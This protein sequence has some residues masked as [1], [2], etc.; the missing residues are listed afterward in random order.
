MRRNG[1]CAADAKSARESL[2]H[3]TSRFYYWAR[4]LCSTD[5]P[6][7][8]GCLSLRE[9]A[10]LRALRVSVVGSGVRLPV[11]IIT[12]RPWHVRRSLLS[13]HSS[14]TQVN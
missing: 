5:V 4:P 6:S 7:V 10:R 12:M 14:T 11:A 9:S 8:N 2:I 13:R 1:P 3:H